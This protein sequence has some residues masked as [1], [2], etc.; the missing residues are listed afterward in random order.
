M[1]IFEETML[2]FLRMMQRKEPDFK[3][4]KGSITP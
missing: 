3:E 2:T 1:P 4:V